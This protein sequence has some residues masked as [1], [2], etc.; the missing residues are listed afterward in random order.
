MS[1]SKEDKAKLKVLLKKL[2]SERGDMY[3]Q[4]RA[5]NKETRQVRAKIKK[6]LVD[7]PKTVPVLATE[8]EIPSEQVLW[9]LM[10]MRKYGLVA[11]GEQD[12]DYF[13]Y[14]LVPKAEKGK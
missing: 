1:D 12:D 8:L 7:E 9:H 13:R 3:E 4:A 11:E 2:R 10:A 5:T 6:A 14:N